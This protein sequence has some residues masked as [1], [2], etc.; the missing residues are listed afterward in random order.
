MTASSLPLSAEEIVRRVDWFSLLW[1][2][3]DDS[4][5]CANPALLAQVVQR[6]S[7]IYTPAALLIKA[8]TSSMGRGDLIAR[9]VPKESIYRA[10]AEGMNEASSQATTSPEDTPEDEFSF[11]WDLLGDVERANGDVLRDLITSAQEIALARCEAMIA[12]FAPKQK[13]EDLLAWKPSTSPGA[14]AARDPALNLDFVLHPSLWLPPPQDG[15]HSLVRRV[16][17]RTIIFLFFGLQLDVSPEASNVSPAFLRDGLWVLGLRAYISECCPWLQA[18]GTHASVLLPPPG[19]NFFEVQRRFRDWPELVLR[20]LSIVLQARLLSTIG[21]SLDDVRAMALA[22]GYWLYDWFD[23]FIAARPL[24]M[25]LSNW[26]QHL[27]CALEA[28]GKML[29]QQWAPQPLSS[30]AISVLFVEALQRGNVRITLPDGLPD[31]VIRDFRR[32]WQNTPTTIT[33]AA[34]SADRSL[35]PASYHGNILVSIT[36]NANRDLIPQPA[37]RLTEF[38]PAT[39][40][41]RIDI[42]VFGIPELCRLTPELFARMGPSEPRGK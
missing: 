9:I 25:P 10:P 30:M 1:A 27:P 22:Q 42:M 29:V 24:D 31:Q 21:G 6:I 16:A 36:P 5:D 32:R 40:S 35:Q 20:H 3:A 34:D 19:V 18:R 38:D 2:V 11:L 17:G 8:F 14:W 26:L 41:W 37:L 15:R 4:T 28:D 7:L 39:R 23:G 33:H 12:E 13:L